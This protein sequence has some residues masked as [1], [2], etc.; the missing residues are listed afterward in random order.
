MHQQESV[1]CASFACTLDQ[2][3]ERQ[4]VFRPVRGVRRK[5]T[6]P[7]ATR[8]STSGRN[9]PERHSDEFPQS[10]DF[11]DVRNHIG[12]LLLLPKSFN[13]SYGD[14][15]YDKK[16]E[17]YLK[18]NLLAQSLHPACY[19]RKPRLPRLPRPGGST[20]PATRTISSADLDA[21]G[22]CTDSAN[23][24]GPSPA[25]GQAVRTR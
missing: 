10:S 13:A 1:L 14:M 7:P 17:Q 15:P 9:R 16:R 8:W 5:A 25:G 19:E 11:Q 21:R 22:P 3:V 23:G 24:G 6:V 20:L 4:S 12:G 2:Y 18:Q